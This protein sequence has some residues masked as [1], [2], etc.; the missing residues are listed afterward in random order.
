MAAVAYFAI[1]NPSLGVTE[2][3]LQRQILFY[4]SAK[5]SDLDTQLRNIGLVQGIV[6]LG[7]SFSPFPKSNISCIKSNHSRSYLQKAD[8]GYWLLLCLEGFG[9]KHPAPTPH[10]QKHLVRAY[11]H[12]TLEHGTFDDFISHDYENAMKEIERWW[13]HWVW[14]WD[15]CLA[16]LDALWDGYRMSCAPLSIEDKL[17]IDAIVGQL[18][19]AF[20]DDFLDLLI[21]DDS[22]Y[23]RS[24][25]IA[26]PTVSRSTAWYIQ[27]LNDSSKTSTNISVYGTAPK[28]V[29]GKLLN[30][31]PNE[32]HTWFKTD[33]VLSLI[34]LGY[35]KSKANGEPDKC[36]ALPSEPREQW[37]YKGKDERVIHVRKEHPLHTEVVRVSLFRNANL[38]FVLIHPDVPKERDEF[39]SFVENAL[40]KL[41]QRLSSKQPENQKDTSAYL[42]YDRQTMQIRSTIPPPPQ[43]PSILYTDSEETSIAQS[44][45]LYNTLNTML[46]V[47]DKLRTVQQIV[48][49]SNNS[50]LIFDRNLSG[51]TV[52]TRD[53]RF[54][55]MLEDVAREAKRSV[56]R[57]RDAQTC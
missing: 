13:L 5:I 33:S 42:I 18:R 8:E 19:D 26:G 20:P 22:G 25:T 23:F 39:W 34:S 45:V 32:K 40:P 10:V 55:E 50:W 27:R 30:G 37:Q 53:T 28:R 12:W 7:G 21:S 1:F 17:E 4:T 43:P 46:E 47:S 14:N 56:K 41:C 29:N 44:M 6:E 16:S 9:N 35:S 36:V 52:I 54:G 3:T 57:L 38:Q 2:E 51:D 15:P 49:L 24:A 48:R 31:N 11:Q